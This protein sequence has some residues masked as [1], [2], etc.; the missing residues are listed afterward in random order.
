MIKAENSEFKPG[1]VCPSFVPFIGA[2]AERLIYPPQVQFDCPTWEATCQL[3]MFKEVPTVDMPHFVGFHLQDLIWMINIIESLSSI[4][5]FFEG[6]NKG[7]RI[8]AGK[9]YLD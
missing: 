4:L 2:R 6:K 8:L 5:F 1:A 7:K 9:Y 3:A